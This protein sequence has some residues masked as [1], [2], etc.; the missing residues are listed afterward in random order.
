MKA[1]YT[2]AIVLLAT[3]IC[4]GQARETDDTNILKQLDSPILLRGDDKTAYRDPA[5][6]YH[7]GV[8]YLFLTIVKTEENNQIFLYTGLSESRDLQTW[9]KP[10]LITPKGQHLNYASPGNGVRFGN[11]WVL[12]LQ[13]YPIP[14][15]KRGDEL[16]WGT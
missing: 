11:E 6:L 13:T 7:E 16:R 10:K 15:Y 12:C 4:Q 5:V 1:Y 9:S 14:N 2:I 8:F 3:A